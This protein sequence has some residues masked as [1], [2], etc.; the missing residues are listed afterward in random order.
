MAAWATIHHAIE[1]SFQ[2]QTTAR[3]HGHAIDDSFQSRFR[4]S[5]DL[6]RSPGFNLGGS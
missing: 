2:S 4:V 6:V 5:R 3:K 1:D